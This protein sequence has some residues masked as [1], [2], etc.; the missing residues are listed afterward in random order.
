LNRNVGVVNLRACSL[1]LEKKSV[2][3]VLTQSIA[4]AKLHIREGG[5]RRSLIVF[6][7]T[8]T[9]TRERIMKKR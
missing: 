3:T 2:H 1:F 6:F 9:P 7:C 4:M 8:S 5:E